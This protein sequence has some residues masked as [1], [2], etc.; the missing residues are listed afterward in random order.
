VETKRDLSIKPKEWQGDVRSYGLLLFL[1]GRNLSQ[2][3]E[4]L[5]SRIGS[6]NVS[7]DG[8]VCTRQMIYINDGES[9]P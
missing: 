6:N 3:T 2:R 8:D 5:S 1:A 7:S 4:N 9:H